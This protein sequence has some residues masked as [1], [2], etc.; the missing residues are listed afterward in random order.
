MEPDVPP[1][2]R[3]VLDAARLLELVHDLRVVGV[4]A[5]AGRRPRARKGGEDHVPRRAEPG[6]FAAPERRARRERHELVKM[7]DQPVH[8]LDRLLGLVD[9]HV[10]VHPEDQ[11]PPRDVLHLVDEGAV[12]VLRGDPLGLEERE[13]VGAGRADAQALLPR[14]VGHVA[15]D[16]EQLLVHAGRRVADGRGHLQHRLH[17]LGVDAR[18]EL[19]SRDGGEHG[20]DVLDEVERLAVEEHVLL[21]HP[22]RVRVARA[23]RVVEDAAAGREVRALARDRRRDEGVAHV[24]TISPGF[25]GRKRVLTRE[26]ERPPRSRPSSADRAAR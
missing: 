3:V 13:R 22:E 16:A 17:Q 25:A 20:V 19:V 4:V 14:D 15:T 21:L 10:Y 18:L 1:D 23:E 7:G 8:D 12:A 24:K 5:E 26:A 9:R 2:V 6:R 11:L